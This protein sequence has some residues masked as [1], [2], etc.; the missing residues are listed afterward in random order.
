MG[1]PWLVPPGD[2]LHTWGF[3]C[4]VFFGG[5]FGMEFFATK[6]SDHPNPGE[7]L[8]RH[9]GKKNQGL[10]KA[11][12][13]LLGVSFHVLRCKNAESESSKGNVSTLL[14]NTPP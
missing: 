7:F 6:K 1:A 5:G 12:I 3:L 14:F 9:H 11:I 10:S 8:R 13:K 4:E 2:L